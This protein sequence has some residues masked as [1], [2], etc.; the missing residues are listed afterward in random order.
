MKR[1]ISRSQ[2]SAIGDSESTGLAQTPSDTPTTGRSH[3]TKFPFCLQETRTWT[4]AQNEVLTLRK[5]ETDHLRNVAGFLMA[6][7]HVLKATEHAQRFAGQGWSRDA[8]EGALALLDQEADDFR[9]IP[10]DFWLTQQPLWKALS[11]ELI[12]RG[13]GSMPSRL[14][15]EATD[16]AKEERAFAR[17]VLRSE[18]EIGRRVLAAERASRAEA[19]SER[20]GEDLNAEDVVPLH[21]LGV[22]TGPVAWQGVR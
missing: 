18:I 2:T 7:R 15:D 8:D 14:D 4:T 9:S 20:C 16:R 22:S 17:I 3:L 10:A 1:A 5:M 21:D 19:Y 6:R 12:R 13:A 11:R